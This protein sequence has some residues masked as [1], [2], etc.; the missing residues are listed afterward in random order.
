MPWYCYKRG[1]REGPI[2]DAV[3]RRWAAL[4]ELEPTD[5][6]WSP[7]MKEWAQ[8]GTVPGLLQPPP[9]TPQSQAEKEGPFLESNSVFPA[10]QPGSTPARTPPKGLRKADESAPLGHQRTPETQSSQQVWEEEPT[11]RVEPLAEAQAAP[12]AEEPLLPKPTLPLTP[13]SA[14]SSRVAQAAAIGLYVVL[15]G[16]LFA[17]RVIGYREAIPAALGFAI[18]YCVIPLFL[19]G[20]VTLIFLRGKQRRQQWLT[21]FMGVS[22]ALLILL[23][24]GE[25]RT[26]FRQWRD[27]RQV[28]ASS[29]DVNRALDTVENAL[30]NGGAPP[31]ANL[32]T[33]PRGARLTIGAWVNE[34]AERAS[35]LSTQLQI[36][37]KSCPI[38][39]ALSPAVLASDE[40]LIEA[41]ARAQR[42]SEVWA[43]YGSA[44]EEYM[45]EMR[46]R[47]DEV[48]CSEELRGQMRT[49]FDKARQDTSTNRFLALEEQICRVIVDMLGWLKANRTSWSVAKATLVIPDAAQ[50]EYWNTMLN[51]L[52]RLGEQERLMRQQTQEEGRKWLESMRK[53]MGAL[54]RK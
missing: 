21:A 34:A 4:G 30:K 46:V 25:L 44:R 37:L 49:G 12:D 3:I 14:A 40:G 9:I 51:R 53:D 39:N 2:D 52:T 36:D 43:S 29:G 31:A 5:L 17:S 54:E 38:D 45:E 7:G 42:R 1:R 19:A 26:G 8:A 32:P 35:R 48:E 15:V 13:H 33:P 10:P 23:S 47:I 27:L 11:T 22:S 41:Q 20:I 28:R 16:L 18:G 24:W 50:R 6:V